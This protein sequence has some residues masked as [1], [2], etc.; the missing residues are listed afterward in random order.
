MS[1]LAEKGSAVMPDI[2]EPS[3]QINATNAKEY[4]SRLEKRKNAYD[5]AIIRRGFRNISGYYSAIISSGCKNIFFKEG[6]S[7]LE[8]IGYTINLENGRMKH[9]GVVVENVIVLE[10]FALNPEVY[11]VGEITDGKITLRYPQANC[12][13]NLNKIE[14]K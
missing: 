2:D 3:R 12:E 6:D 7:T 13:I 5:E 4:T 8:Q 1:N 14:K 11:L 9:R 10:H